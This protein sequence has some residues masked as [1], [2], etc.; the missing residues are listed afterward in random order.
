M[1]QTTK[2]ITIFYTCLF[3]SMA[4]LAL[5]RK[6]VEI[7]EAR[8][9]MVDGQ[10]REIVVN[11]STS[12]LNQDSISEPETI[13]VGAGLELGAI[14]L[15]EP[16]GAETRITHE[17]G[18]V[19]NS[20]E[21]L[22]IDVP[23][24][25]VNYYPDINTFKNL[26][27]YTVDALGELSPETKHFKVVSVPSVGGKVASFSLASAEEKKEETTCYSDYGYDFNGQFTEYPEQCSL[28]QGYDSGVTHYYKSIRDEAT[29]K[30]DYYYYNSSGRVKTLRCDQTDSI[31]IGSFH[32]KLRREFHSIESYCHKT[33]GPNNDEV[34]VLAANFG[35]LQ[36]EW[37][38]DN[39]PLWLSANIPINDDGIIGDYYYLNK[40]NPEGVLSIYSFRESTIGG[41][42]G[43]ENYTKS[44][45]T[46][47]SVSVTHNKEYQGTQKY[48]AELLYFGAIRDQYGL[49]LY[50][51]LNPSAAKAVYFYNVTY[52]DFLSSV[53]CDISYK[54]RHKIE[55]GYMALRAGQIIGIHK[56]ESGLKIKAPNKI[57]LSASLV[58]GYEDILYTPSMESYIPRLVLT[59]LVPK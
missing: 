49:C 8:N 20:G 12:R 55:G 31:K 57:S 35:S 13:I 58:T 52:T 33:D 19:F 25:S 34:G 29:G 39:W 36:L 4:S 41:K 28:F 26:Y 47:Q 1:R 17:Y 48:T 14:P 23:K 56:H 51:D 32:V 11:H 22:H 16:P 42:I 15:N 9:I 10:D 7:N 3:F 59:D 30:S 40:Q 6:S 21:V 5:E 37:K 45:G 18:I 44:F 53:V 2:K 54:S 43:E 27:Y 24:R 50:N 46:D 38:K